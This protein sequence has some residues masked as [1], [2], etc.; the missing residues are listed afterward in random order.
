MIWFSNCTGKKHIAVIVD[1]A[2]PL[3]AKTEFFLECASER[4]A[5]LM[6]EHLQRTVGDEMDRLRALY[7]NKGWRDAKA[8]KGA[9]E[10]AFPCA[11]GIAE[12][13]KR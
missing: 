10:T 9:K 2:Y 13:E 1:P 7:Y 3:E 4:E 8:K 12:W 11:I 5:A 6:L